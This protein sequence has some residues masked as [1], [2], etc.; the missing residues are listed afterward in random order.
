MYNY[1]GRNAWSNGP[2]RPD[3]GVNRGPG[4]GPSSGHGS[5]SGG[6]RVLVA[7]E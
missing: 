1:F 6:A 5:G 3:G 7:V 4:L 2:P